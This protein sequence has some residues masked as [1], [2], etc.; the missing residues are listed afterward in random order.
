MTILF[1]GNWIKNYYLKFCWKE[2]RADEYRR[3]E[4]EEEEEIDGKQ[5]KKWEPDAEDEDAFPVWSTHKPYII[6]PTKKK[7]IYHFKT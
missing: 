5:E 1:F 4:G 7:Y 6:F 2:V 3:K